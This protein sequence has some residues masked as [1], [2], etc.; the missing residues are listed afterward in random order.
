MSVIAVLIPISLGL[1]AFFVGLYLWALHHGQFSDLE[2]PRWRMLF[3]DDLKKKP[4]IP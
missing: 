2:S 4:P 1:G 3:D